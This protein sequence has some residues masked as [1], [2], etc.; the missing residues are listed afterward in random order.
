MTLK[1]LSLLVITLLITATSFAQS[2]KDRIN[3][4]KVAFITERLDL[5]EKEAQQFWP[6]Y[7]AFKEQ[8]NQLREQMHE[9]RKTVDVDALTE[10]EAEALLSE[11]EAM[12]NKKRTLH[13]NLV[14][15]LKKVLPSK[16][17]VLLFKAE[18]EFKRKMFEEYKRRQHRDKP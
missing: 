5:S 14:K 2:K 4:L 17:I 18:D 1:K 6:I 13:S 7:N 15:D 8:N 3:S 11:M 9:K 10:A 12:E 16:K